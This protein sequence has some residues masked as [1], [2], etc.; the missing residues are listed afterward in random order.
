[1]RIEP[2]NSN[3]QTLYST[4]QSAQERPLPTKNR[5]FELESELQIEVYGFLYGDLAPKLR[6]LFS[7]ARKEDPFLDEGAFCNDKFMW[8]CRYFLATTPIASSPVSQVRM[9]MIRE[10][11]HK[12]PSMQIYQYGKYEYRLTHIEPDDN[13]MHYLLIGR[14]YNLN[15]S[16]MLG[17]RLRFCDVCGQ[18]K[19]LKRGSAD[20]SCTAPA[21][22][23]KSKKMMEMRT[24]KK[25]ITMSCDIYLSFFSHFISIFE[26]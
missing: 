17:V 7:K 23:V 16:M 8:I 9:R 20:K 12:P 1:M 21:Q 15:G 5:L 22:F 19:H 10:G 24:M 3:S 26:F 13:D 6:S 25:I 4:M 18:C 14:P 11:D 2:N